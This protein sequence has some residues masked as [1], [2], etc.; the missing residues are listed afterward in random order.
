[1]KIMIMPDSFKGS[2]S[3][4][5]AAQAIKQGF[6]TVLPADYHLLPVGDGGEGTLDA[7]IRSLDLQIASRE[8]TGPFGEKANLR[9][10]Y[11]QQQAFFEMADLVGLPQIPEKQRDPLA[12]QTKGLG[13]ML[14][15]LAEQGFREIGIG[16]GGSATVDGGIGFA[17]GLGY[18]FFDQDGKRLQPI[19]ASLTSVA[20][21]DRQH[22][23]ELPQELTVKIINDVT[24]PLCGEQGA[25]QIF[26]PQKGL[27]ETEILSVDQALKQF[28]QL[29]NPAILTL[30]GAGAG[31]GLAAGIAAFSN[32]QIVSGID[33]VLDLQEFDQ[34]V[35]HADLVIVGEGRM[36]QQSLSGKAPVGIARRV[37]E[38]IPVV[39]ICGSVAKELRDTTKSGIDAA[40]PIV[41]QPMS[42][43]EAIENAESNLIRTSAAIAGLYRRLLE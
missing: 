14:V 5:E 33:Y 6:E 25:A 10:A 41:N 21:I 31:G 24:N 42:L 8:V 40:F 4:S 29:A 43:S 18:R 22:A 30:E 38:G 35:Q 36:D 11:R 12:I 9:Y 27:K 7:L 26:G 1:M 15:Y 37:P 23:F 20:A 39:A 34:Q 17:A 16:I 32:G 2:L 3:A 19:G 13:E 28:Y